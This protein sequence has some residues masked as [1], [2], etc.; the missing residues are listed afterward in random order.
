MPRARQPKI[1]SDEKAFLGLLPTLTGTPR[2][3]F[4]QR[5]FEAHHGSTPA[6]GYIAQIILSEEENKICKTDYCCMRFTAPSRDE[7]L[8]QIFIYFDQIKSYNESQK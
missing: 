6:I 7:L 1:N 8:S 2:T 5:T 4:M 3:G